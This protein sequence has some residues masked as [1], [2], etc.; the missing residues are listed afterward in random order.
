LPGEAIICNC[1][2]TARHHSHWLDF[3]FN[4]SV[5]SL[6][7]TSVIKSFEFS[8]ASVDDSC[9][10]WMNKTTASYLML[11]S[12]FQARVITR[13]QLPSRES[14]HR[15]RKFQDFTISET[16]HDTLYSSHQRL[17]KPRAKRCSHGFTPIAICLLP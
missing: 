8:S 4:S 17:Q 16:Q 10:C 2:K 1:R 13:M 7:G 5:I 6:R 11:F 12:Q 15:Y 14:P 3:F 9:H